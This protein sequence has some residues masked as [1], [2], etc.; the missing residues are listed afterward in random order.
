MGFFVGG[1]VYFFNQCVISLFDVKKK[2]TT[3]IFLPE[4]NFSMPRDI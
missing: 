3:E 2:K 1:V 4:T